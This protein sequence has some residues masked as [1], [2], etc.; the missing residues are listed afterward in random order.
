MWGDWGVVRENGEHISGFWVCGWLIVML[1]KSQ[2]YAIVREVINYRKSTNDTQD[3]TAHVETP[4]FETIRQFI[5]THADRI[6]IK[7]FKRQDTAVAPHLS[8]LNYLFNLPTTIRDEYT[9]C[10]NRNNQ[11]EAAAAAT[12]ATTI[13]RQ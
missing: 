2:V 10:L 9:Y 13:H 5:N 11:N 8:R 12:T 6:V 3:V 4:Q 7:H 1:T